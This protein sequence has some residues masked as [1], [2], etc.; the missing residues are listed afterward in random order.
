MA[1][2]EEIALGELS[3]HG[4]AVD[5]RRDSET[6]MPLMHMTHV[7]KCPK[8]LHGRHNP[9]NENNVDY[10]FDCHIV[11]NTVSPVHQLILMPVEDEL[12]LLF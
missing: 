2:S 12:L 1:E 7:W 6:K 4:E 5:P 10:L 9:G 3:I 8:K 11:T